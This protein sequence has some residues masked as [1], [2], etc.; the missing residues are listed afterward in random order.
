[1]T[2]Y[3]LRLRYAPGRN[4]RFSAPQLT[5]EVLASALPAG[6]QYTLTPLA[7]GYELAIDLDR[8]DHGQAMVDLDSALRQIGF[9]VLQASITEFATSWIEGSLIGTAGGAVLGAATKS[10]EGFLA[11]ALSGFVL[12]ALRQTEKAKYLAMP[13]A[14]GWQITKRESPPAA[15]TEPAY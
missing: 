2:R 4:L 11:L 7:D 9:S 5:P 13:T 14:H 8:H 15:S 12:G 3:Q 10:L 6:T 1:M